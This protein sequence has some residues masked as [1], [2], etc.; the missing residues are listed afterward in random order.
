MIVSKSDYREPSSGPNW[1][2]IHPDPEP[3]R[4][5]STLSVLVRLG[6]LLTFGNVLFVTSLFTL[7][8]S[9]STDPIVTLLPVSYVSVQ[10]FRT[11]MS[12]VRSP[13]LLDLVVVKLIQVTLTVLSQGLPSINRNN[14]RLSH[15]TPT[16]P[17]PTNHT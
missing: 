1:V 17:N 16:P 11:W 6:L 15:H 3:T 8:N 7:L 5:L 14:R 9:T 10:V 13:L 2:T 4:P 12:L